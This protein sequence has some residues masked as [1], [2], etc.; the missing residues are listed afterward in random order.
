MYSRDFC[1]TQSRFV[2]LSH[3][4]SHI[5][6]RTPRERDYQNQPLTP[7]RIPFLSPTLTSN[8][9]VGGSNPSG[10]ANFSMSIPIT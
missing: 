1:G 4:L 9:V 7:C 8:Q 10:R 2:L 3:A 6:Q 5:F